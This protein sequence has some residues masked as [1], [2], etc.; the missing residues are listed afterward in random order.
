VRALPDLRIL[1]GALALVAVLVV[2]AVVRAAYDDAPTQEERRCQ[3][4]RV[5]AD[6]VAARED[7]VDD[8]LEYLRRARA[9]ERA[10]RSAN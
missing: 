6:A 7:T 4:L 5:A 10:C 2:L 3:E 9:A 8:E 1:L